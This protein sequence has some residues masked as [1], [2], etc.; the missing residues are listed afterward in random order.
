MEWHQVLDVETCSPPLSYTGQKSSLALDEERKTRIESTTAK[1]SP[2]GW[3][4]APIKRKKDD[5]NEYKRRRRFIRLPL[6]TIAAAS[7]PLNSDQDRRRE[8]KIIDVAELV[9][10]AAYY[11][12]CHELV[13]TRETESSRPTYITA[14]SALALFIKSI[15]NKGHRDTQ[16]VACD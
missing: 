3:A 2:T 16:S 4:R 13:C 8:L 6:K 5:W 11:S 1:C 7:M 14:A 12:P 15:A 9:G 10:Y